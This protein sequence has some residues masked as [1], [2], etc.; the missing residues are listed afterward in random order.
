[1]LE[2][3]KI[4]FS[5]SAESLETYDFVEV[6]IKIADP[7]ADNPFTDVAVKGEFTHEDGRLARVDGFCDS[8]DGSVFCVRFMPTKPGSYSY[9]VKYHQDS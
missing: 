6:V 3:P 8:A 4:E 5:Q 1:M 9:S 7:T 2:N